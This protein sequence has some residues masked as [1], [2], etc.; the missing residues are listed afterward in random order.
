L[1][2]GIELCEQLLQET[3]VLLPTGEVPAAPQQ[4]RLLQGPLELPVALLAVAV[5]VGLPRLDRLT[6]QTVVTQKRSVTLREQG[7]L[8]PG[9]HRRC[10][11]I[12]AMHLG[13]ATQL[14][15]RV[16]QSLAQTLIALR[17]ADRPRLP[18]RVGQHEVVDQVRERLALDGHAQVAAVGEV[19]GTQ[20][21]R[22]MHLGEEHFLGGPVQGPPLLD[23]PLQR[24]HLPVGKAAGIAALQLGEQRLGLQAGVQLQQ[25]LQLGPDLGERI[26]AGTPVAV[27]AFDL[28][29]QPAEAAVLA[30]GLGR[31][32]RPQGCL[33]LGDSLPIETEQPADLVILDHGEPPVGFPLV[34]SCSPMGNSS[35]RRRAQRTVEHR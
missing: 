22:L 8:R 20:P 4:Q 17:E 33:L 26:H 32:A 23:A 2:V 18:V 30:G 11:P 14:P 7:T 19:A 12:R 27:H 24:P 3:L 9:W 5:L 16:L 15:Q 21:S 35:C 1:P 25:R 28:T 13:D 31:H 10:Q 29:G 34:Y 6:F